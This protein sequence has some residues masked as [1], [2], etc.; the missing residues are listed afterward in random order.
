MMN[1]KHCITS[2]LLSEAVCPSDVLKFIVD[3]LDSLVSVSCDSA[4]TS[5]RPVS[6]TSTGPSLIAQTSTETSLLKYWEDSETPIYSGCLANEGPFN[7]PYKQSLEMSLC[8]SHFTC[9]ERHPGN[10]GAL[11]VRTNIPHHSCCKIVEIRSGKHYQSECLAYCNDGDHTYCAHISPAQKPAEC[12]Q[13]DNPF[14]KSFGS[15]GCC[16]TEYIRVSSNP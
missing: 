14:H 9:R 8:N 7:R 10:S 4:T 15:V 2:E 16:R 11:C 1:T 6:I 5:I 13:G 3:P 12:Y